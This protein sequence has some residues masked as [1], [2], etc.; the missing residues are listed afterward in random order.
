VLVINQYFASREA[1]G[2]LLRELSVRL[3]DSFEV[4]VVAAAALAD[5]NEQLDSRVTVERVAATRFPRSSPALRAVNYATFMAGLPIVAWRTGRPDVVLCMTDPPIV[6]LVALVLAR[7]RRVPVIVVFQDVHPQLGLATGRLTNPAVVAALRLS[8]RVLLA[9][10][11]RL[12]A[13]GVAMRDELVKLGASPDS[14]EVIPN[15]SDVARGPHHT[16]P[17]QWDLR[18][19]LQDAFVVMHAGNIG[20]LQGLDAV[21]AAAGMVP[22]ARFLIVGDGSGRESLMAVAERLRCTNV[23]FLPWQPHSTMPEVLA[24]ADVQLVTLLPGLAG[25]LEPSKVYSALASGR[26]LLVALDERS[27]GAAVVRSHDCG[28]VV[29]PGDAASIAAGVRRLMATPLAERE[30]M[31]RRGRRYADGHDSAAAGESYVQLIRSVL[32]LPADPQSVA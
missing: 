1:T 12:V 11:D 8:Q 10:P 32:R 18:H 21:V 26:P 20:Q 6:G 19:G 28:V 30:A 29:T 14:I 17:T 4:T 27:E 2:Q 9:A 7:L 23:E 24:S 13:I 15:W 5:Y 22:E 16:R 31:G 3:S 25:L